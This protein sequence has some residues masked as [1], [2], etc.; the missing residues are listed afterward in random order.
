MGE[1]YAVKTRGIGL[2]DYAQPKPVGSV[3]VGPVYTSTDIAELAARQGSPDTFDRRGNVIVVDGFG[4]GIN[5]WWRDPAYVGSTLVWSNITAN[6]GGYSAELTTAA[7]LNDQAAVGIWRSFPILGKLGF[8]F[9]FCFD[10]Y[11]Y[12]IE[13][14]GLLYN[15]TY[16]HGPCVRWFSASHLC[17]YRDSN[18]QWRD[19]SP[20]IQLTPSFPAWHQYPFNTIKLVADYE[21]RKYTRLIFNNIA[22]DLSG[23]S[24]QYAASVVP[25]LLSMYIR[26]TNN[27]AHTSTIYLDDGIITQ[28]E[29]ANPVE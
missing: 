1:I 20:I 26:I 22:Y 7:G 4:D 17:Q 15:G 12:S 14:F 25:P 13:L 19:L 2:P 21:S 6:H 23:E 29:P 5:K 18:G 10:E 16:E 28:N 24:Y 8:E 9:S 27:A 11:L 3:P